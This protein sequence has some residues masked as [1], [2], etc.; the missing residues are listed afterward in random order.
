MTIDERIAALEARL[1]A[2]EA[3]IAALELRLDGYPVQ[4]V[5]WEPRHIPYP[6][7]PPWQEVTCQSDGPMTISIPPNFY[8]SS[9]PDAHGDAPA[10][11]I[12]PLWAAPRE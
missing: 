5:P 10:V 11:T 7:T 6:P 8:G 12:K 1:A 3:R 2:A 4:P 9:N